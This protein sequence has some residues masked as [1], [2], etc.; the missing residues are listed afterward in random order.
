[1]WQSSARADPARLRGSRDSSVQA[2]LQ[3]SVP[4]R[5]LFVPSSQGR[6]VSLLWICYLQCG[7]SP[8][9]TGARAQGPGECGRILAR[10]RQV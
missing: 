3:A 2:L 4:L 7:S 5:V 8:G 1:M 10:G 9:G 6:S